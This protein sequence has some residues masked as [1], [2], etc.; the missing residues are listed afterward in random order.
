[1][2]RK[3]DELLDTLDHVRA[4]AFFF[5]FFF[6]LCIGHSPFAGSDARRSDSQ[7]YLA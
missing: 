6:L 1:M 3:R 2:G 7:K 5:P 4:F